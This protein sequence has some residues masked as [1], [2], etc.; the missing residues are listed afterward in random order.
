[1]TAAILATVRVPPLLLMD[2]DGVLNPSPGSPAG[3]REYAIF[4]EDEEPVRLCAVH[5]DWLRELA[6][7]F[8]LVWA[9]S[10]GDAA[11]IH[12]CPR[13]GLPELPV[14]LFPP[15][16]F[17]ASAK[18]PAIDSFVGESAVAWVDDVVTPQTRRWADDRMPPTLLVEVNHALG[19]TRDAVDGVLAWRLTLG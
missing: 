5:G 9:T 8:R 18:L 13:F 19:Q 17:D 12:P 11:N 10:W 3:Y 15:A 7:H 1:M 6:E 2:V 14:I 16:P 4:P